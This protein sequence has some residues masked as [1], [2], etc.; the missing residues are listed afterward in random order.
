MKRCQ[1][2]G[3]ASDVRPVSRIE[4]VDIVGG[5]YAA[6]DDGAHSADNDEL[7][8][9]AGQRGNESFDTHESV[10][11]LALRAAPRMA[12]ISRENASIWLTRS[13]GG[14]RSCTMSEPR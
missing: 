4:D 11:R 13:V 5:M 6:V 12:A 8:I 10:R 3:Q 7:H 9:G 14:R 2:A 1:G